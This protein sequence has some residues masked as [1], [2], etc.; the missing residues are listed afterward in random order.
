MLSPTRRLEIRKDII[1][2][3]ISLS[4]KVR[5]YSKSPNIILEPEGLKEVKILDLRMY[6]DEGQFL[7][8]TGSIVFD[9]QNKTAYA[10]HSS[11]TNRIL[12]DKVCH[13]FK[14]DFVAFDS[15]DGDGCPIYHTNVMMW[16]GTNIA[17]VCLESIRDKMVNKFSSLQSVQFHESFISAKEIRS[18]KS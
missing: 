10:C 13:A 14:Y 8:G 6:S 9:Y 11:R 1:D 3:L 12:L 5:I 2:H 17:A 7:E 18:R 16:I 15:T 4:K